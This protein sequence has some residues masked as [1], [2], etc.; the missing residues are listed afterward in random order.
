MLK[1]LIDQFFL[2]KEHD[3]D[4]QHFYITDAGKCERAIFFK[5]KNVPREKMTA[6]ILRMLDHG[7]YVQMHILNCLFSL[8]IVRSSEIKIPPQEIISGRADA[9]ITIDND[10]YVVDFKSMNGYKFKSLEAPLEDNVNQ[11]Q[12]YMHYF[13]IPRGIL[14]YV[15]KNTLAL[16]EFLVNYDPVLAEFLLSGLKK[17]KKKIDNDRVPSRLPDYPGNVQCKYCVFGDICKI[18][19]AEE[20]DW[21]DFKKRVK[22]N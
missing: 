9:I 15:D 17:L 22:E 2:D 13:G 16:K 10:L 1:D 3:R 12:L 18:S 20:I 14:L 7:D 5:F 21:D 4:Q 11:I 6:E 8:G 19:G